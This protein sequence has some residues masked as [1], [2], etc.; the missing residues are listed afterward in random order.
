MLDL[1]AVLSIALL[2]TLAAMYTRGC[3]LLKGARR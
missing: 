3:D 2:F 1:A